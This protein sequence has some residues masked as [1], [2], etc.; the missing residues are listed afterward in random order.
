MAWDAALRGFRT[1]LVDRTDL[2]NGTSGRFHGLLHSGG[3]YVVK[4]P[5]AAEECIEENLILRQIAADDRGHG[6][7]VRQH[8]RGRHRLWR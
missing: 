3:R 5:A 1:I 6:R 2:A 8:A 4:D 7:P